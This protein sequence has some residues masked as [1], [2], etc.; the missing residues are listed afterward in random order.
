M[1][2]DGCPLESVTAY[3]RYSGF[4]STL[5]AWGCYNHAK[6]RWKLLI[7]FNYFLRDFVRNYPEGKLYFTEVVKLSGTWRVLLYNFT[8]MRWQEV[9]V[10]SGASS[11][12]FGW[13]VWE[14]HE[15][16]TN[17]PNPFYNIESTNLQ[18]YDGISW[19]YCNSTYGTRWKTLPDN[20][21]YSYGWYRNYTHWY[22]G[23]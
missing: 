22:V 12:P 17:W 21:A 9:Y 13:D 16:N 19:H 7:Y 18:V 11:I 23:P 20:F 1:C 10:F 15:W 4:T 3:W 8:A 14:S 5:R 2:P 6:G